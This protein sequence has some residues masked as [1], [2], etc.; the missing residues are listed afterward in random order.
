ML[1]RIAFKRAGYMLLLAAG[2]LV[3]THQANAQATSRARA[4]QLIGNVSIVKDSSS[5][6]TALFNGGEVS[7]GQMIVT[8]PDG[9]ARFQVADGST[10]EVFPDSQVIFRSTMGIGDLLNV[11]I[12]KI[13]VWI[14]HA[15][16]VPNPNSVSTPTA[17]ISVRGTVFTV[18]VKDAEGTT[19]VAVDEGIVD[20]RNLLRGGRVVRLMPGEATTV[21]PHNPLVGLGGNRGMI[22][23]RGLK[24]A[25]DMVRDIMLQ[26]PGS[27]PAPTAGGTSGGAQGDKGK[28]TG[29]TGGSGS[30]TGGSGTGSPT[31]GTGSGSPTGGTG[32]PPPGGGE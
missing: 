14:Q 19:D 5:Y 28:P 10:F 9:Y 13:K 25:T 26:R 8:G 4:I 18:D 11:V 6:R 31:G 21:D 15:P 20:V 12:G 24:A 17:L 22:L 16:G 32:V 27:S 1:E 7:P 30:P 3:C 23:Q 29:S 2:L